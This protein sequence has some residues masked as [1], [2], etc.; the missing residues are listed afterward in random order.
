M[1]LDSIGRNIRKYRLAKNL[2]QEDIAEKSGLSTNYIGMVERGEKTPSLHSFILIINA[3]GV[4]ADVILSDLTSNGYDV[5][6]SL[7][8]EKLSALSNEDKN[9]IY[10]VVDVLIKHAK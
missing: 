5:K 6:N 3:L 7:F 9:R 4:S 2:R 8:A 1:K 10:D